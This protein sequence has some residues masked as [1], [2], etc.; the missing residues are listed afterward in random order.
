LLVILKAVKV[1]LGLTAVVVVV[2]ELMDVRVFSNAAE[3][4]TGM[5]R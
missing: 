1:A 5:A 2:L 4:I 3:E